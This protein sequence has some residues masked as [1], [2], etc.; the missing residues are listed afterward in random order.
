MKQGFRIFDTHTHMGAARH[1]R[2]SYGVD[3]LLR[4]MDACGV[5][6]SVVIPFP[7]VEDYRRQHDLIGDA[8]KAYPDRLTGA[9]SLYPFIATSD[10]RDEVRRC[11]EMYGFRAL[12][13]QPQYHGL[14]P[15]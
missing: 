7:V 5:D 11:R 10:F 14:N 8:V 6:R 13:L 3:D 4:S 2:R 9:A 12:K 1:S 15:A